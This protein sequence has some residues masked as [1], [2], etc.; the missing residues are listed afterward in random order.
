[1][2]VKMEPL[3][4][5]KT[6]IITGSQGGIGRA[7]L[8]VFAEHGAHIYACVHRDNEEFFR[9]IGELSNRTGQGIQPIIFDLTDSTAIKVGLQR[10]YAD[11]R[12]IDILVNN[13]GVAQGS[14]LQ[15]TSITEM[16]NIFDVNFFAQ[17]SLIQSV[18]RHM[19]R[20]GSGSIIN[21]TSMAGIFSEPGALAYGC[22]KAALNHATRIIAMELASSRVRVNAIAP[23][24]THTNML[25][26]MDS[27][28]LEQ[29]VA[30]TAMKRAAQ[31]EEIAR[32][33]LFL[34]SDLSSYMTGQIVRADGG[35]I[36]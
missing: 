14:L 8:Q 19:Q 6:A 33:A 2:N 28:V 36:Y 23:N 7:I 17:I 5:G 32:V 11:K 34:A 30:R 29:T 3:L 21:I 16:K 15:M 24:I 18:S 4:R 10:I 13:A 12:P 20:H 9:W 26:Q 25:D 22:S 35:Q 27:K 31:P 1:M